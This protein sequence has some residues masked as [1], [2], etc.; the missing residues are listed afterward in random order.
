M[1]EVLDYYRGMNANMKRLATFL[2]LTVGFALAG[3]AEAA[4]F[5]RKGECGFKIV[6]YQVTGTAGE[7]FTY[8]GKSWTIPA[9]GTIEIVAKKN[10][11][12]ITVSRQPFDLTDR[13]PGPMGVVTVDLSDLRGNGEVLLA[14]SAR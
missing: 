6:S 2:I 3:P 9:H 1:A 11:S 7:T 13:K 10:A 14:S 12:T 8:A 5:G 4:M